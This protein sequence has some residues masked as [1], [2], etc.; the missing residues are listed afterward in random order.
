[1]WWARP[2]A[3]LT[4]SRIAPPDPGFSASLANF[5]AAAGQRAAACG[6]AYED[7]FEWP[8]ARGGAK[9][10]YE[11]Q[12]G[13]GRRGPEELWKRFDE[14][15]EELDQVSEGRS[16]RAVGRAYAALADVASQLA[17]EIERADRASGVLPGLAQPGR[18]RTAA[19]PTNGGAQVRPAGA[20]DRVVLS[21]RRT[22]HRVMRK[23]IARAAVAG[24]SRLGRFRASR[25][26]ALAT[27]PR[28]R[29][30]AQV[31]ATSSLVTG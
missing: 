18:S 3:A 11:L 25:F 27:A 16:L 13:T 23:A 7:G 8:P 20:G 31:V 26:V 2:T 15:V 22:P 28:S 9:L 4:R 6:V 17:E 24:R 21:G 5:A 29:M 10:P 19:A 12:P 14:A 1:M 30:I